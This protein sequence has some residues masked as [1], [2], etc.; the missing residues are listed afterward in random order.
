M[1]ALFIPWFLKDL[2]RKVLIIFQLLASLGCFHEK[3]SQ[4]RPSREQ[5]RESAT[6]SPAL[7]RL[8]CHAPGRAWEPMLAMG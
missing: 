5:S 7:S 8:C 1:I 6:A 3:T 2:T 4:F